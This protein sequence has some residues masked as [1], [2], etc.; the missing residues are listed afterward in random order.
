[1]IYKY[2]FFFISWLNKKIDPLGGTDEYC[3][4]AASALVGMTIAVNIY[5]VVDIINILFARNMFLMG[6]VSTIMD[7]FIIVMSLSSFIY[8]KH[9]GRWG[10][11]YDSILQSSSRQK[12]RYGICCLL[13]LLIVYGL[14]FLCND[15]IRVLNTG[16]GITLAKRI[17]ISLN[18]AY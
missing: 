13:Y 2:I 7:V 15:I 3:Y 10:I 14:W 4:Y 5:V 8:F 17:V 18:S 12:I 11:V 6:T 9:N 1:M 16:D